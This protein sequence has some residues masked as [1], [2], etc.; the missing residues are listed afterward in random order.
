MSCQLLSGST[1]GMPIPFVTQ[2]SL[3]P[4]PRQLTTIPPINGR[5]EFIK[6]C[7]Q[8]RFHF[9]TNIMKQQYP[10]PL[11]QHQCDDPVDNIIGAQAGI[12]ILRVKIPSTLA[13]SGRRSELI[14]QDLPIL[15]VKLVGFEWIR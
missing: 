1:A 14:Q 6:Y 4:Y 7:W 13:I 9:R 5:T 2:T 11:D 15:G 12:P 3:W 8:S 10:M